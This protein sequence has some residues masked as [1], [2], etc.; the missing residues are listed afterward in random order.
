MAVKIPGLDEI[1]ANM[2][3]FA[4][5]LPVLESINNNLRVLTEATVRQSELTPESKQ[6]LMDRMS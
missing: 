6:E 3:K 2:D 5:M 4:S 1:T